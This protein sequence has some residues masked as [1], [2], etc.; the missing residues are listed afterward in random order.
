MELQE[1]TIY[2][3]KMK[4]MEGDRVVEERLYMRREEA[5]EHDTNFTD[6]EAIK[7][8]TDGVYVWEYI[9]MIEKEKPDEKIVACI[10]RINEVL[11]WEEPDEVRDVY[12]EGNRI[13]VSAISQTTANMLNEKLVG[14][15]MEY[16]GWVR[17]SEGNKNAA[18][19][20]HTH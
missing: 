8:V 19:W 12:N 6:I 14:I 9:G 18:F 15:D 2:K 4:N 10:N 3:L 5:E 17:D 11:E 16:E 13:F 7:A 1:T 20:V